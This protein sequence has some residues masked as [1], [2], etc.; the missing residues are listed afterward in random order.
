[1]LAFLLFLKHQ[2]LCPLTQGLCIYCFIRTVFASCFRYSSGLSSFFHVSTQK[3]SL[4]KAPNAQKSVYISQFL[5]LVLLAFLNNT[6]PYIIPF[7]Y[8]LT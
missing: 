3:S 8:L 5:S 7:I 1:M 4:Q 6:C 2:S